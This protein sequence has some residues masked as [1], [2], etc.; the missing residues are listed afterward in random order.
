VTL[1]RMVDD[2]FTSSMWVEAR[3]R[4]SLADGT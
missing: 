3:L 4:Q 2:V 1:I